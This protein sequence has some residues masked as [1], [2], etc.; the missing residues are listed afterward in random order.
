MRHYIGKK[1]GVLDRYVKETLAEVLPIL[2]YSD[3]EYNLWVFIIFW[4]F[5]WCFCKYHGLN[6]FLI[7][8]FSRVW[9][10]N[11]RSDVRRTF[12]IWINSSLKSRLLAPLGALDTMPTSNLESKVSISPWEIC[13][14]LFLLGKDA[15][16]FAEY[17]KHH[18]VCPPSNWT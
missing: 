14:C 13:P 8:S 10:L 1:H 2:F 6:A 17:S 15:H 7:I 12:W 5:I 11:N 18:L 16:A 3:Y 4:F 9:F